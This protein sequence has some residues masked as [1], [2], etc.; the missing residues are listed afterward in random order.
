MDFFYRLRNAGNPRCCKADKVL[1]SCQV[2]VNDRSMS[3]PCQVHVRSMSGPCQVHVRSMSGPCQVHVRSMSGPCQV[4]KILET[5]QSP[6]PYIPLGLDLGL[7][8]KFS[9]FPCFISI[10]LHNLSK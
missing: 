8:T 9:F 6:N 2:Q 1:S 7:R 4:H 5:A 10:I 3:G